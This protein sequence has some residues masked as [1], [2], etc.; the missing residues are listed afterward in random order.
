MNASTKSVRESTLHALALTART[1]RRDESLE[2][3]NLVEL[4]ARGP[5][6]ID[7]P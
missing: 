1:N 5:H 7:E 3:V 2:L 4:N 6:S